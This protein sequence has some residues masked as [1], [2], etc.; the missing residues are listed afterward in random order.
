[1]KNLYEAANLNRFDNLSFIARQIVEGFITGMHKSP[2]HGFSVEFAEH[3]IYNSGE[4]TRH[5]DWKL[6][7][8]TD[9]LFVKKY[10]EETNLRAY[11]VLDTSSSMYFPVEKDRINKMSFSVYMAA[12]LIY[13]LQKQR[14][15]VGLTLISDKIDLHTPVKTSIPHINFLYDNLAALLSPPEISGSKTSLAEHL[16][17][18]SEQIHRRSLVIIF[19]DLLQTDAVDSLIDGLRHLKFKK[20]EIILIHTLDKTKEEDLQYDKRPYRFID[21]ETQK[22]V[23]LNPSQI[24]KIYQ[25]KAADFFN[26]IKLKAGEYGVEVVEADIRKPFYQVLVP[27]VLKRGKMF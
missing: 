27:F 17:R 10:E 6:F 11:I 24:Q 18:L 16:H 25:Q 15:A 3:R 21:L 20:N 7:A 22:E 13:M 1:M 9:R 23:K 2:F 26:T 4:S 12:A 14:D 8:R 19:T 5:I